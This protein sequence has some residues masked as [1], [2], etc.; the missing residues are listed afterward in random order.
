MPSKRKIQADGV[1]NIWIQE[2]QNRKGIRKKKDSQKM[3]LKSENFQML[4]KRCVETSN[5]FRNLNP[6][7]EKINHSK[8][9]N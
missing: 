3:K 4:K 6:T 5:P 9:R 2:I 7:N 1:T 8:K